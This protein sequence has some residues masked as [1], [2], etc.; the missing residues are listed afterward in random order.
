MNI[1]VCNGDADGLC[2]VV[3]WRLHALKPARLVTGLKRDIALL[4][5][6]Q[7]VAGDAVLVCDISMRR[8]RVP[9]LRLLDAGVS[10]RYFD[11]HVVD[12]MPVHP[13]LNT[14]IDVASD[15]CTSLLV[16][17]YLQGR[18]RAWALVGAF[19]DN[20]TTVADHLAVSMGLS[21]EGRRRLQTLG[22]AIN[23]NAY[24]DSEK[25]VH[26]APAALYARMVQYTD[27]L[28][29]WARDGIGQELAELRQADLKHALAVPPEIKNARVSVCLLPNAPWSRRV[30]G[31]LIN[32]HAAADPQRAHALLTSTDQGD[33]SVSVRAPLRAPVGAAEF[34]RQFGGDGRAGAAGIDHL[35]AA[36]LD[37]FM[38]AF[39]SAP[40]G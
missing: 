36:Q 31:S 19:G 9:L 10:V 29:F 35:P 13:L 16:D 25:D 14:T 39:S 8:N 7:A 17:R 12:A 20:L 24:G 18:F 27:P 22:E 11:H 2:A 38:A 3:Q 1:D 40:W 5:R 34:C 26:I 33:F 32:L 23:Y 28:V 37:C 30:S 15:T 21:L 4:E 6:V